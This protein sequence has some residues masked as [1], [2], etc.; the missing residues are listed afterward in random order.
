GGRPPE[1]DEPETTPK[2]ARS[3]LKSI[4]ATVA[5]LDIA[6]VTAEADLS[7]L[8]TSCLD[9]VQ[10]TLDEVRLEVEQLE[11]DGNVT[12]DAR[13]IYA[14]EP[15]DEDDIGG[16][17]LQPDQ[18]DEPVRLKPDATTAGISEATVAA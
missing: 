13:A 1:T 17:R 7:H 6:R 16:V 8:A 18:G 15:A 9:T 11:R 14:D 3:E 12:P 4:R 5:E 10:A 2:T